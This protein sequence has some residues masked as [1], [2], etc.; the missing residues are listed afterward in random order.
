MKYI[1]IPGLSISITERKA[2]FEMTLA[3]HIE[4]STPNAKLLRYGPQS[5][6]PCGGLTVWVQEYSAALA[7]AIPLSVKRYS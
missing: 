4:C 2:G 3:L 6:V 1:P 7:S 5:S